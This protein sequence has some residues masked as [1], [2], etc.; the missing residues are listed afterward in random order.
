MSARRTGLDTS[1]WRS[2]GISCADYPPIRKSGT[3][4]ESGI[5]VQREDRWSRTARARSRFNPR[6]R[7]A[8]RNRAL[9]RA[10][11]TLPC[12]PGYARNHCG[13]TAEAVQFCIVRGCV[14][15]FS[16]VRFR[17]SRAGCSAGTSRRRWHWRS[18]VAPRGYPSLPNEARGHRKATC[19]FRGRHRV[20]GFLRDRVPIASDLRDI[21]P[22][23][24]GR[25][26]R[27][28]PYLQRARLLSQRGRFAPD[29]PARREVYPTEARNS[30]RRYSGCASRGALLCRSALRQA[31]GT[32]F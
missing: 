11:A 8:R 14:R 7:A 9:W 16:P 10:R 5:A 17:Q 22:A 24:R 23:T 19:G 12:S 15:E 28:L 29:Q 27:I 6:I 25:H 32:R 21:R 3:Y 4:P 13:R 18:V 1:A 26:G 31:S 2:G 20:R 30:W